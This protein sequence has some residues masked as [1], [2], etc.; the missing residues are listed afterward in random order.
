M[1][2]RMCEM[3]WARGFN[4]EHRTSNFEI[5][6]FDVE[7]S[8][9]LFLRRGKSF[10][11]ELLQIVILLPPGRVHHADDAVHLLRR[12]HPLADL[13]RFAVVIARDHLL[14]LAGGEELERLVTLG[15]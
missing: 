4:I 6:M 12:F 3:R 7:C 14:V 15:E 10:P 1:R 9:F 2:S 11:R 13:F 5:S 8:M